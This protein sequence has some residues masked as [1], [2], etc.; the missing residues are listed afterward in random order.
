M[1]NKLKIFAFVTL[2]ASPVYADLVVNRSI[3]LYDDPA[4]IKE[5]IVILNSDALSNLYVQV[6]AFR[7][8]APGAE[9]QELEKIIP[10]ADPEFLV[11]PNKLVVPPSGRNIVRFLDLAQSREVER[12]YRV[13]L[14]PVTPPVELE[15]TGEGSVRSRLEVVVAYQVLAIVLPENPHA[16]PVFSRDGKLASFANAGNSNYLLT[17]GEQCNPLDPQECRS[18]EN[19]RIY[20]G[21][22]WTVELPWDGPFSYKIKTHNGMVSRLFD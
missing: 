8:N 12:V 14:I 19:R 6:D 9:N 10:D 20:P 16:E 4:S 21:N 5:D 22:D 18:L 11:S 2:F 17:E 3:V 1:F 13:N 7:V 15:E